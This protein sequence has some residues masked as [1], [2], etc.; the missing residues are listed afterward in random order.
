MTVSSTS[1]RVVYQRQ[2][3]HHGVSVRPSRSS[4]QPTLSSSTLT[5]LAWTSLFPPSQY[6]ASGFGLD[7]GGSVT[8]PV[9][10]TPIASGTTLTIYRDV[11]S[12]QP[13]S[14]SN[15]ARCGHR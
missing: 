5:R 2:R 14:I 1:N 6:A 8:Y 12:T 10:G 15:Q 7:A 3:R 9:S 4:R 11:A 13:T